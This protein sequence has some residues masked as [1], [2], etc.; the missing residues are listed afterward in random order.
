MEFESKTPSYMDPVEF[1][2]ME[3]GIDSYLQY[4]QSPAP[5]NLG[6]E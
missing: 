2:Y 5:F 1:S 3:S 4:P 6:R